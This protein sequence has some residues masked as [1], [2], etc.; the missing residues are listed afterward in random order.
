[1]RKWKPENFH[2]I[3]GFVA[4][5]RSSSIDQIS[6]ERNALLRTGGVARLGC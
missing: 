2:G 6:L 4:A 1:M 5:E 3:V